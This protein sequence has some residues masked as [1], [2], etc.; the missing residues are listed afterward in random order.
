MKTTEQATE[1]KISRRKV[2]KGLEAC[3]IGPMASTAK[4]HCSPGIC[5]YYKSTT[6][7]QDLFDDAIALIKQDG[8]R[9]KEMG[10]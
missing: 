10:K 6:C 4:P 5:P 8:E 3:R 7:D 2:L 1:K 9:L